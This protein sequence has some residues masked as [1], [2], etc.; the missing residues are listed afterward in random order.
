MLYQEV[1]NGGDIFGNGYLVNGVVGGFPQN[2]DWPGSVT[3]E[4]VV[5]RS[6]WRL[7]ERVVRTLRQY[8]GVYIECEEYP[9][10]LI[11]IADDACQMAVEL[12][13]WA[14]TLYTGWCGQSVHEHYASRG[15]PPP[16]DS[17][18][19]YMQR[20]D[21]LAPSLEEWVEV[22]LKGG[23]RAA[24]ANQLSRPL[25]RWMLGESVEG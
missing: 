5:S 3:I 15:L 19:K 17:E 13:G 2:A 20:I 10:R 7:N 21:F 6:D 11:Q 16:Q 23:Q 9:D 1:G 22:V 8:P 25:E 24:A 18:S 14:G 12:D 4:K